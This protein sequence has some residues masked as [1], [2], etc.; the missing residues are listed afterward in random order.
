MSR[1]AAT[2]S[3]VGVPDAAMAHE[4]EALLENRDEFISRRIDDTLASGAHGLLFIGAL[5]RVEPRLPKSIV[6]D[7]PLGTPARDDATGDPAHEKEQRHAS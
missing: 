5:H 7:H 1:S 6:I 2:R 3:A 4:L